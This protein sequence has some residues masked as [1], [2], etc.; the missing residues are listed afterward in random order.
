M[1]IKNITVHT[2]N[3]VNTVIPDGYIRIEN[4]KIIEVGVY[5]ANHTEDKIMDGKGLSVYPGFIDAHTHLG[6]FEDGIAFEG[7]DANESTEPVTP[8]LRALDAVNPMDRCFSEAVS[9]GVT[10]VL[11]GPGSANPIAG[12]ILAMKTYGRRIDDMLVAAPVAIKF[13]LGENPKSVYND[14]DQM[15]VTRMATAA[16]IRE[17]LTKAKKYKEDRKKAETNS[18]EFDPP[19]FDAKYEALMPLLEGK[20]PAH[21]HAHRADDIFT[22]IRIAKE[23]HIP[24]VIVHATEGHLICEELKEENAAVLSGPFL[25]DR[26]KPELKNLTTQS[27]G[28]MAHANIPTA[29]ITDHPETPI[30]Y[31]PIC[32]AVAVREGMDRTDA[33]RAITSIP[34][35]ICGIDNRVGSIEV[36]KDADLLFFDGDPLNIMNKPKI[37]FISGKRVI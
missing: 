18:D 9:A 36:G 7:D 27:A 6:I 32:A 24:Y 15:P 35:Q 3:S 23:F 31:L 20:I 19:E 22:A 13:A 21:F 29:I 10:T 26:S 16:L 33:L 12:Q 2:M 17:T 37:V 25:T 8:Q 14:K 11:T 28:I 4:G 1:I 5:N 30:Q 34:A